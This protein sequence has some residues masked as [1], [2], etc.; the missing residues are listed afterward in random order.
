M[1][2]RAESSGRRNRIL[3]CLESQRGPPQMWA[4]A[5]LAWLA[6]EISVRRTRILGCLE[7]QRLHPPKG[8]SAPP[9][10]LATPATG[11]KFDEQTLLKRASTSIEVR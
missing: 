4:P 6:A 8:P 1:Q 7:P 5:L 10:W 3:G 2:Q 11:C 9:A